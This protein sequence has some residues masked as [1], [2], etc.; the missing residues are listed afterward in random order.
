M[1]ESF[2]ITNRMMR[3]KCATSMG[4]AT[5]MR[6]PVKDNQKG[7][8]KGLRWLALLHAAGLV[9]FGGARFAFGAEFLALLAMQALG[10]GLLRTFQ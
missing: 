6:A 9:G 8:K 7:M 3:R 5:A 4:R 2:V 1:H 10:I